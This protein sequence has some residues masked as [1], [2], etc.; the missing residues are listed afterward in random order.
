D[1]DAM[2]AFV[3]KTG[4]KTGLREMTGAEQ[5]S[6]EA[7]AS[8]AGNASNPSNASTSQGGWFDAAPAVEIPRQ[9]ETV[10]TEAGLDRWIAKIDTAALTSVDTET[11]SLEPLQA[12]LVGISLCCE[13][14]VACYIPVAHH[15]QDAPA[16]LSRDLV[17]GKMRA[18]LEDANKPKVGQNLKYDS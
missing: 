1:R 6:G 12:P 4:V 13:P 3:K 9:Y 8:A 17:L 10:L 5:A 2:I 7:N 11:T 14:G 18:W 15:Y 16:Q